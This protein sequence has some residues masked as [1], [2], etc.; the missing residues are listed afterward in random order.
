MHRYLR[1]Q[2]EGH[3]PEEQTE[4]HRKVEH[5]Q[6]RAIVHPIPQEAEPLEGH[7]I[8]RGRVAA[9]AASSPKEVDHLENHSE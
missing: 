2:L 1:L 9:V 7:P 8:H 5:Q 6:L 4:A 3:Q